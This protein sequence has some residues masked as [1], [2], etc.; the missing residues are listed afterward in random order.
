MRSPITELLAPILR[1]ALVLPAL[2]HRFDLHSHLIRTNAFLTLF[3]FS[4]RPTDISLSFLSLSQDQQSERPIISA[5]YR[6]T[7]GDSICLA[8]VSWFLAVALSVVLTQ[9]LPT[10]L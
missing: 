8:F 6:A 4:F 1:F 9:I 5:S 2:V 3:V 10:P 7:F